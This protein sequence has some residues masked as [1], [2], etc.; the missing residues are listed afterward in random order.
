MKEKDREEKENE[1]DGDIKKLEK[2]REG[3]E[4]VEGEM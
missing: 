4:R 1:E 3:K 2:K